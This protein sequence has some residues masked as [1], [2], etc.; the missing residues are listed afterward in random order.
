MPEQ[1]QV[2]RC[3]QCGKAF[4]SSRGLTAHQNFQ[5]PADDEDSG[6][7]S[8]KESADTMGSTEGLEDGQDWETK[9]QELKERLQESADCTVRTENMEEDSADRDMDKASRDDEGVENEEY[10]C[11]YCGKAFDS[12]RGVTAHQNFHCPEKSEEVSADMED[13]TEEP[14]EDDSGEAGELQR[15]REQTLRRLHDTYDM[16]MEE[17]REMTDSDLQRILETEKQK[18]QAEELR[19]LLVDE[20]AE[21][22]DNVRALTLEELQSLKARYEKKYD[23]LQELADTYGI[24]R[25]RLQDKTPDEL[26]ELKA[27]LEAV[28]TKKAN[29]LETYGVISIDD[30]SEEE[31]S[32]EDDTDVNDTEV[33]EEDVSDT[34]EDGTEVTDQMDVVDLK[35]AY[36]DSAT[37]PVLGE[38]NESGVG[39]V[40]LNNLERAEAMEDEE[41]AIRVFAH[42]LQQFLELQMGISRDLTY[43]EFVE[44]LDAHDVDTEY[45]EDV[46][47]FYRRMHLKEEEA[48]ETEVAYETGYELAKAVINELR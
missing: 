18:E 12:S 39:A 46:K 7:E 26:Q 5:C 17:L 32:I 40:A 19:D 42:V 3:E 24:A 47:E 6:A 37:L 23:A 30:V 28:E 11:E 13:P 44:E 48:A 15:Q 43:R 36:A 34:A 31:R 2:H 29:L 14:G 45:V 41:D 9:A 8:G 27:R 16:P 33:A 1:S 35:E 4:D 10:P 38:G 25:E 22:Q 20:Y 21:D